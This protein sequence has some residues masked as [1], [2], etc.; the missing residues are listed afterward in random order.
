MWNGAISLPTRRQNNAMVT[1]YP[2][3]PVNM[4]I[5]LPLPALPYK[6]V[7]GA[8]DKIRIVCV[9]DN[10]PLPSGNGNTIPQKP[11]ENGYCVTVAPCMHPPC[12]EIP[13]PPPTPNRCRTDSTKNCPDFAPDFGLAIG[14]TRAILG[15][16]LAKIQ[17]ESCLSNY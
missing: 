7:R 17:P 13:S 4:G 3:T 8:N 2:E 1:L 12:N 10:T 14:R 16:E 11:G 9:S 5:V 6:L 15:D